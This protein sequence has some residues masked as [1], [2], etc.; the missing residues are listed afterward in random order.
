MIYFLQDSFSGDIKIGT[1]QDVESRIA[2]LRAANPHP[3]ALLGILQ[4]GHSEEA[5]WH[6]QFVRFRL[7]NEW[8]RGEPG[9]RRKIGLA[10]LRSGVA[11][12]VGDELRRR[13]DCRYGL[14]SVR[15]GVIGSPGEYRVW[16]TRWDA[17]ERLILSLY[18]A[19]G[20][21]P[22]NLWR[23]GDPGDEALGLKRLSDFLGIERP[24]GFLD[25]VPANHCVLL[26]D[27]PCV[28]C[29]PERIPL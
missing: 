26:E 20:R 10:L 14:E 29:F 21:S 18:P 19:R 7:G 16:S 9:L 11:A 25:A 3:V 13:D 24:P 8:F 1:S 17:F 22:R 12:T 5:C 2:T 6:R 15:V 4:G 23:P 27:W 28:C